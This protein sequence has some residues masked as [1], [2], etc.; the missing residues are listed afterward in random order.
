LT[1]VE[2]A[3]SRHGEIQDNYVRF[4]ARRFLQERNPVGDAA[5]NFASRFQ[6][7]LKCPEELMTWPDGGSTP[8][9]GEKAT[10]WEGGYR[11]P[12][13]IR[14]PG[15]IKAG[16]IYSDFF[17]HEDFLPTFAAAAGNANIVDQCMKNC[18]LG[19]ASFP[20]PSGWLQLDAI[21]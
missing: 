9:R 7:A 21:L 15:V 4:D 19:N 14:W 18:Q 8:Y 16:T 12:T 13:L 2:S 6:E 10:N 1:G 3:P 20:R 11:V 17:A 5:H